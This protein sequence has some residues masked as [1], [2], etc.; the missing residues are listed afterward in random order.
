M[1]GKIDYTKPDTPPEEHEVRVAKYFAR[2]GKDITFIR[3]SNIPNIH[4]P[5]FQM[6]G[7][8]GR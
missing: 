7:V 1:P 4:T 5:D 8:N 3:P 6:D 2:R